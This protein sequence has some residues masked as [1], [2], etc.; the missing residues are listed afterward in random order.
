[1]LNRKNPDQRVNPAQE[2][3]MQQQLQEQ[4]AR[5]SSHKSP[6]FKESPRDTV[7]EQHRKES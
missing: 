4:L 7:K 2:R 5:Q 3:E 6:Q 1:M